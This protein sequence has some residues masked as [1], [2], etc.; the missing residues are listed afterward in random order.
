MMKKCY[1]EGGG[2]GV[3]MEG[4]GVPEIKSPLLYCINRDVIRMC[5][6]KGQPF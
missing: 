5:D 1:L 4:G 2:E 6:K 3:C